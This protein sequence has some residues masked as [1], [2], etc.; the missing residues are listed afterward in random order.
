MPAKYMN[1]CISGMIIISG[2]GDI[3]DPEPCYQKD[4]YN[5]SDV[6]QNGW[7]AKIPGMKE[8]IGIPLYH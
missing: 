1:C 7:I 4:N 6:G 8:W 5:H 3:D 2:A